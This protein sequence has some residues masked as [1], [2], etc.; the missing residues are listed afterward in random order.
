MKIVGIT[1]G[2]LLLCI[3]ILLIVNPLLIMNREAWASIPGTYLVLAGISFVTIG[4][5]MQYIW[6]KQ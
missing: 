5:V 2:F 1:S 3:G 6:K 4:V